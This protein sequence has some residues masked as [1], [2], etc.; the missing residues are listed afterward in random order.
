MR[1]SHHTHARQA[2]KPAATLPVTSLLTMC[3]HGASN[4]CPFLTYRR[5]CRSRT[6]AS[7]AKER[8]LLACTPA[9][10][11]EQHVIPTSHVAPFTYPHK[12]TG[13]S[14]IQGT[15]TPKF[16]LLSEAKPPASPLFP[17]RTAPNAKSPPPPGQTK[18]M[19]STSIA[20]TAPMSPFSSLS[21]DLL[22]EVV[23]YCN[24]EALTRLRASSRLWT[25]LVAEHEQAHPSFTTMVGSPL[26]FAAKAKRKCKTTPSVCFF[27]QNSTTSAEQLT[28]TLSALPPDCQVIGGESPCPFVSSNRYVEFG[29]DDDTGTL[30]LLKLL[31]L[32]GAHAH[33]IMAQ[34]ND[35]D[36]VN[37]AT[38]KLKRRRILLEDIL[39]LD[40]RIDYKM[41]VIFAGHGAEHIDLFLEALQKEYP[42]ATV[43]GGVFGPNIF[44]WKG[45]VLRRPG[46]CDRDGAIVGMAL[47]GNVPLQAVVSRG[48]VPHSPPLKV[49]SWE[50]VEEEES[51]LIKSGRPVRQRIRTWPSDRIYAM[52]MDFWACR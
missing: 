38:S 25:V 51:I 16:F 27:F 5:G 24:L 31:S 41:F 23:S 32:P 37:A 47:W 26:K 1:E 28:A 3:R 6:E 49:A 12:C 18:T 9:C 7:A 14:Q 36:A 21:T 52:L 50:Y 43:V 46:G 45:G 42:R 33:V 15:D 10:P 2:S 48:V 20:R 8:E 39:G 22:L 11:I 4:W 44:S 19:A 40:S 29:E 34:S 13:T 17:A 30:A 35:L